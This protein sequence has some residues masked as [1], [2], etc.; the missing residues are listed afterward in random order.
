MWSWKSWFYGSNCGEYDSG[1]KPHVKLFSLYK[2]RSG[3]LEYKRGEENEKKTHSNNTRDRGEKWPL[4]KRGGGPL[5]ILLTQ[6]QRSEGNAREAVEN[7]P[8]G[9]STTIRRKCSI[10][11]KCPGQAQRSQG[12]AQG[13]SG[14]QPTRGLTG[15]IEW[16][17]FTETQLHHWRNQGATRIRDH[18][19]HDTTYVEGVAKRP[20]SAEMTYVCHML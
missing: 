14:G 13:T 9:P 10:R 11:R 18:T 17:W 4:R 5:R 1:R 2:I 6:A 8:P 19:M 20:R 16:L 12:R 15:V 7:T 3:E